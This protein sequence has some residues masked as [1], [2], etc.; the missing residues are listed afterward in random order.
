MDD[1]ELGRLTAAAWRGEKV[2]VVRGARDI[3]P[4]SGDSTSSREGIA[5][6]ED[7]QRDMGRG[8]GSSRAK[9]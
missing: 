3:P 7:S 1:T 2:F 4:A 6:A 5:D 8:E 9:G